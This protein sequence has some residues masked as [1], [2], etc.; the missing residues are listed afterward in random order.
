MTGIPT[1]SD[2]FSNSIIGTRLWMNESSRCIHLCIVELIP[3]E[4]L[5]VDRSIGRMMIAG[6]LL[7]E[8][9]GL[10]F[11]VRPRITG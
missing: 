9:L 8:G 5:G 10:F 1:S 2:D 7:L 3:C 11:A 4:V 6:L